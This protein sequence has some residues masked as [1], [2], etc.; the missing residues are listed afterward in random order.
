MHGCVRETA[1]VAKNTGREGMQ[2]TTVV[3]NQPKQV[4][5]RA[6]GSTAFVERPR[7]AELC[8]EHSEITKVVRRIR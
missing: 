6:C 8:I 4:L 7:K 5:S 1:R 2:S 3:G